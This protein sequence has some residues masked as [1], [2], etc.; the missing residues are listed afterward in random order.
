MPQINHSSVSGLEIERMIEINQDESYAESHQD[1]DYYSFSP[2][3]TGFIVMTSH[4][5]APIASL[6]CGNGGSTP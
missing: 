4:N 5:L 1:Q 2:N 6:S 3:T